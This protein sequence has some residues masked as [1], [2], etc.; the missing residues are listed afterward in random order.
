MQL[1]AVGTVCVVAFGTAFGVAVSAQQN[2]QPQSQKEPSVVTTPSPPAS[3][4]SPA[5]SW[6]QSLVET[7]TSGCE[8]DEH[9]RLPR[10]DGMRD[11]S[12]A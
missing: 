6:Q 7:R 12:R 11:R 10:C 8:A 3:V 2:A 9:C 1:Q 4:P 5:A